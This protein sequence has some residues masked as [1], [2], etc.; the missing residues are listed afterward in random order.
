MAQTWRDARIT[1]I[2]EGANGI[3][4]IT[5]ATRG[6]RLNDGAGADAFAALVQDLADGNADIV[7]LLGHWQ[8]ERTKTAAQQGVPTN[9]RDFAGLT[10]ELFF[11][12][13]WVRLAAVAR[14]Q[15]AIFADEFAQLAA[16]ITKNPP[17][18]ARFTS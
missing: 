10:A 5:T 12:A 2:Y 7:G 14:E 8:G 1:S 13:V 17:P 18:T 6:L 11:R 3:H 15:D 9:A 16:Q 4:A